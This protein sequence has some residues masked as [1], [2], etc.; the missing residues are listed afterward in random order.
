MPNTSRFTAGANQ[1]NTFRTKTQDFQD[2]AYGATVS[3]KVNA[4]LSVIRIGAL[5]G[6]ITINPDVANAYI[7]DRVIFLFT[8]DA[9]IRTITLGANTAGSAATLATVASKKAVLEF[10]YD[11]A[12][13]LEVGRTIGA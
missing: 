3:P 10:M 11:G 12:I 4:D 7:G 5:T 9:S 2:I 6:N 1:D 13:W 8:S